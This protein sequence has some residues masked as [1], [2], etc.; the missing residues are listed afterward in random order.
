MNLST[1]IYRM[2][3]PRDLSI[4]SHIGMTNYGRSKEDHQ[5]EFIPDC[6]VTLEDIKLAEAIYGPVCYHVEI[7]TEIV[8]RQHLVDILFFQRST[9]HSIHQ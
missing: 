9:I 3:E 5:N 8:F 7:Q 4:P 1:F 2:N 6:L